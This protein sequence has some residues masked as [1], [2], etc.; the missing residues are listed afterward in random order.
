MTCM[1]APPQFFVQE[2]PQCVAVG[3]TCG[4]PGQRQLE[5]C[6]DAQCTNLLGGSGMTCVEEQPQCVAVGEACGGPGQRQL[7]CC[8][9]AQCKNLPGGSSMTC[10]EEQP[11]CV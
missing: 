7:E 4:G 11:Q 2:Q 5:C 9:D 1:E 10:M 3:E 8:G 6:G